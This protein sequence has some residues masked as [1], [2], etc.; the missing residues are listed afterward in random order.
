[1]TRS[2]RRNLAPPASC[3]R[4]AHA[5]RYVGRAI[6]RCRPKGR[7]GARRSSFARI[8]LRSRFLGFDHR[9]LGFPDGPR[10]CPGRSQWRELTLLSGPPVAVYSLRFA[11]HRRRRLLCV[12]EPDLKNH[13]QALASSLRAG[14]PHRRPRGF[15]VS[16]EKLVVRVAA[17]LKV[18]AMIVDDRLLQGT[19]P[20]HSFMRPG[21]ERKAAP[22]EEA[23]RG[24]RRRALH[25]G[26]TSEL[27]TN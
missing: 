16:L 24:R 27:L 23:H 22:F 5:V 3:K 1:M 14:S 7:S 12:D 11:A 19:A 9:F 13:W 26:H 8:A 20:W 10:R 4:S 21:G 6:C 15:R 18:V 25:R 2:L 17:S